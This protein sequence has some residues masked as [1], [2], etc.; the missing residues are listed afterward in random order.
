MGIFS[1]YLIVS[2]IDGTLYN[3]ACCVSEENRQ[4][5]AYFKSEGGLFTL[6][7]GRTLPDVTAIDA[8]IGLCNTELIGS[9]GAVIGRGE[10]VLRRSHFDAQLA[11]A[12]QRILDS[13]DY[14]DAEFVTPHGIAVLRPN[15][16]TAVHRAYVTDS[17]SDIQTTEDIPHDTVMT[18]FWMAEDSIA[19]FRELLARLGVDAIYETFQGFRLDYEMVPKGV[20]KGAAARELCRMK[21]CHTLICAGDNYNDIA[22]LREADIS[23]SPRNAAEEVRRQATVALQRT[24]DESIYPEILEYL[25]NH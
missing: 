15:A 7:S 8:T 17:F 6:A 19:D 9:N 22:M 3:T 16:Q 14:C 5:L 20:N 21:G 10:S 11:T 2:D 18:S 23:F 4:A 12:V 25:R 1:G 13:C 24:C